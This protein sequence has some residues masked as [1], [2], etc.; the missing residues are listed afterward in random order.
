MTDFTFDT[1]TI[2]TLIERVK[3]SGIHKLKVKCDEFEIE[4]Q[5]APSQPQAVI[6]PANTVLSS[7]TTSA[8]EDLSANVSTPITKGHV[9]KSPIIGTFYASPSPEKPPFVK[10]GQSVN[11]G[12]VLFIIES[13]KLM[14]EIKSEY[15]G[16]ITNIL[17][18]SGDTVEYHQ[19]IL[20]IE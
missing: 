3:Q 6:T 8:S 20:T 4:I 16:T 14:N 17:V 7:T 2:D 15:T 5:A 9:V 13:M 10:V 1:Q 12:D 18:E 19:P 11:E